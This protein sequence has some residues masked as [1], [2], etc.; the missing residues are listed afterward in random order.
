MSVN[1]LSYDLSSYLSV[2][3]VKWELCPV[4]A[5]QGIKYND[6]SIYFYILISRLALNF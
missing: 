3:I 4:I 2:L 6:I 5:G 1:V